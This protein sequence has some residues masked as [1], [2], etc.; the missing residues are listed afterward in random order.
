L[1]VYELA[2]GKSATAVI[3]T[4]KG[5]VVATFEVRREGHTIT[6]E[7][8][9]TCERFQLLLVGI[10]SVASVEGGTTENTHQGTLVKPADGVES[11]SILLNAE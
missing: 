10:P 9:G 2:D 4:V 11:L 8:C 1:Q 7:K 6:V 5:D 3:P